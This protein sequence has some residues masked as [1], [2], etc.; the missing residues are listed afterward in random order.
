MAGIL[1]TMATELSWALQLA[2]SVGALVGALVGAFV[3]LH[4]SA[5]QPSAPGH[6]GLSPSVNLG[7]VFKYFEH[8]ESVAQSLSFHKHPALLP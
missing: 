7:L 3:H 1:G 6:V 4:A 8:S 5:L 2:A